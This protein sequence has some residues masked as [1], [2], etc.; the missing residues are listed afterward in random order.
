MNHL[1]SCLLV[2]INKY[3]F[4]FNSRFGNEKIKKE[5]LEP[6]VKGDVVSCIG[7]SEP[8]GGSDVARYLIKFY[9]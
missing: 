1:F 8:G 3:L 7:V 5:F 2:F 9:F 6:S 4:N